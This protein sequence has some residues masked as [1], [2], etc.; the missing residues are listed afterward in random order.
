MEVYYLALLIFAARIAD[1]SLGTVRMILTISGSKWLAA[2]FGFLELLIWVFAVGGVVSNLDSPVVIVAYAGGF[3]MGTIVGIWVEE[4]LAF[5]YRTVLVVNS[6]AQEVSV[7]DHVRAGGF[8]AT[9]L[10]GSGRS[11]PVE[12]TLTVIRRSAVNRLLHLI[13]EAA[14]RSF[15]SVE[16]AER[17]FT[18]GEAATTP[19]R[20]DWIRSLVRK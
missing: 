8:V 3:A 13:D 5:G 20:R 16:R 6:R 2:L 9:R 15:V 11:G 7:A 18:N 10:D 4:R 12:V 14:P 17:P 1:V 19:R